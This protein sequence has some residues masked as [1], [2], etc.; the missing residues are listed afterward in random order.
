MEQSSSDEAQHADSLDE[1]LATPP[2]RFAASTPVAVF[3][4]RT[5][6]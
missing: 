6:T 1:S 3:E 5:A 2:N 4:P